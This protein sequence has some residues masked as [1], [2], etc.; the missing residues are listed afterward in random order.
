[1]SATQKTK[2]E[3]VRAYFQKHFP[4]CI[5]R[6]GL[7]TISRTRN[8]EAFC[9]HRRFKAIFFQDFFEGKR[10]SQIKAFLEE[11]KLAHQLKKNGSRIAMITKEDIRWRPTSNLN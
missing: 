10:I 5:V 3:T 1:M 4:E 9:E 6:A 11:K 8:F 7:D 2:T